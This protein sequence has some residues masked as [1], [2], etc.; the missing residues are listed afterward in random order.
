MFDKVPVKVGPSTVAVW[1]TAVAMAV[2]GVL[3]QGQG[4][5]LAVSAGL[6]AVNNIA[7][8]YQSIY[9]P[10]LFF[11]GDDDTSVLFDLDDDDDDG[12]GQDP[13]V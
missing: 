6:V 7:R 9:E 5:L 2:V 12:L 13:N 10:E 3:Q 1:V 11:A 4:W 8:S